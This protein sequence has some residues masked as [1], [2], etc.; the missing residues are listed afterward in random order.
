MMNKN[1]S[2]FYNDILNV[3]GDCVKKDK[4]KRALI[5]EELILKGRNISLIN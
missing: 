1:L 5:K 3:I 2:K 4:L